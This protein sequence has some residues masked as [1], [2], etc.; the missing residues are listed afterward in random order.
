MDILWVSRKKKKIGHFKKKHNAHWP[1]AK[2]NLLESYVYHPT[3]LQKCYKG[4]LKWWKFP[5][6]R[7]ASIFANK[8]FKKGSCPHLCGDQ[9]T[10]WLVLVLTKIKIIFC[11]LLFCILSRVLIYLFKSNLIVAFLSLL[12]RIL[13]FQHLF[14]SSKNLDLAKCF[15]EKN[16]LGAK[17]SNSSNVATTTTNHYFSQNNFY[18]RRCSDDGICPNLNRHFGSLTH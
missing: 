12:V 14:L 9:S 1:L 3:T 17:C 2:A 16:N 4:I 15:S 11:Y 6:R 8:S 18:K 13:L 10:L 7:I 5:K